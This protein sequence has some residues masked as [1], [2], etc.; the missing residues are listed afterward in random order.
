M[1][2]G[3]KF[4]TLVCAMHLKTPKHSE[5]NI[6]LFYVENE[7]I[8]FQM[9]VVCTMHFSIVNQFSIFMCSVNKQFQIL[10][11]LVDV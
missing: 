8:H 1:N 2:L 7:L 3:M 10:S 9:S 11:V 6:S 5:K 4:E